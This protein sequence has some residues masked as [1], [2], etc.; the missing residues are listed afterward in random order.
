[1]IWSEVK[2]HPE[3]AKSYLGSPSLVRL[4]DGALL[5]THDYYGLRGCPK[6]HEGEESLT[7][8][9]RS[10]DDGVSWV[11]VNHIMNCY[12][13][14]LF[15]HGG[16]VYILGTSQQ[17]GSVVIRRS[18]DGGFT[19]THPADAASG[20]LFRGGPYR[21]P[22]NYHCAP[23]PVVHH[24]G[25]IYK[26]FEDCN[27]QVWGIGFQACVISAP[28]ESNLLDAANWTMSNKMPFDPAWLP[29]AWGENT[30]PGWREGN[31]V[32]APDGELWNLLT[33]E[34]N[35]MPQE[36]A[37]RIKIHDQGR[38][39]SFDP[40][41]GF[42]DFPGS[43][44]K[45]TVRR[46]PETGVYLSIVNPLVDLEVLHSLAAHSELNTGHRSKHPYRQRNVV[47]LTASEDLWNWRIVTQLM[48]DDSGLE[49]KES[50]LLTGF[51]YVDWQFDGDDLI[52][53]AR[54]AYRGT[55]NFHDANRIVFRVLKDF[56][57]LL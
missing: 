36:K 51:Q 6:N 31:V 1:M 14:S 12:W 25:R 8:V 34:A 10:E 28:A 29:S 32:V 17:Y 5:A 48:A 50:I 26:A 41:S 4:P 44:A 22:P 43:K 16:S 40:E 3:R 24:E 23:V 19:W 38:R 39:I 53:L 13:S 7:S 27:P 37:A 21:D 20:L 35:P 9:Y 15:V 49:P 45:F 54:T 52:Y 46:D 18:D 33:F 30:I 56:R 11:N 47:A 2:Y 57:A 42:I 55:R